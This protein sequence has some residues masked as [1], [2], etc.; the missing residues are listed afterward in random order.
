MSELLYDHATLTKKKKTNE[1]KIK[2]GKGLEAEQA[3]SLA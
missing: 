3:F 2:Y 1:M